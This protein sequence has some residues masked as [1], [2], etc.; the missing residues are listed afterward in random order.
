MADSA[1]SS[2]LLLTDPADPV[3]CLSSQ[4]DF[5]VRIARNDLAHLH[6]MDLRSAPPDELVLE[7]GALT[8]SLYSVL[9]IIDD[10]TGEQP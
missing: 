4:Q 5:R 10:L 7:L 6:G 3:R 9:A 1:D 8:A 2:T